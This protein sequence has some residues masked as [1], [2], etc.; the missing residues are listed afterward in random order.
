MVVVVDLPQSALIEQTS[1]TEE[2]NRGSK[3][4]PEIIRT[5]RVGVSECLNEL[6]NGHSSICGEL[7]VYLC[8]RV[9]I[10]LTFGCILFL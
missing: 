10:C 9:G 3:V 7:C 4:I 8:D 5:E 6:S 2:G 1:T